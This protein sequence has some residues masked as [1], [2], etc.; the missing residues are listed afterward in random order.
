MRIIAGTRR[1]MKLFSPGKLK[2]RPI[3]DRVKESLFNILR[4]YDLPDGAVVA[5][6]F[7]GVGSLGLESLSRGAKFVTFV[8]QDSSIA[9]TLERN[10]EKAGFVKDSKII[11]ADAFKVGA[12][13][14][15]E[16]RRYG[17]IFI[18]PPYTFTADVGAD[19]LLGRLLDLV[20]G[21]ADAGGVVVVRTQRRIVLLER[22]GRLQFVERRQWGTMAVTILKLGGK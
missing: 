1:G 8:E 2:S 20:Q 16:G 15:C 3:T 4:N 22:Y 18:D 21:Q 12:V 5:D 19:S 7:C 17:L 14:G 13:V 10:I 9:V 11:R 6:L